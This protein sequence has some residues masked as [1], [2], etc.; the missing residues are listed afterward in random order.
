MLGSSRIYNDPTSE[1]PRDVARFIL[2][3]SPP[4]SVDERRSRVRYPSP[5][6]SKELKAIVDFEQQPFCNLLISVRQIK[7]HK[8]LRRSLTGI[9]TS[10]VIVWPSIFTYSTSLCSLEPWHVGQVVFHGIWPSSP[11]IESYTD[12]HQS[13]GRTRRCPPNWSSFP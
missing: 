7:A 8:S 6:S 11:C 9:L 4:E 13:I 1:E 2:W 10:S 3:L 12:S 5:T